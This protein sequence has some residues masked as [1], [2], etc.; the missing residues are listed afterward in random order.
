MNPETWIAWLVL[1]LA[2]GALTFAL[3]RRLGLGPRLGLALA[4]L[5][6]SAGFAALYLYSTEAQPR[7]VDLAI[8]QPKNGARVEGNR[9]RVEGVAR[10]ASSLVTLVVRSE[11]DE[12]WWV[13]DVVRPD[14]QSGLWLIDAYLGTPTEGVRQSFTIVALASDDGVLL[15]V[16]AGRRLSRGMT[17]ATVPLWNRSSP[18]VVWRAR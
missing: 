15:N 3:A 14:P 13:Q 1:A 16:L 2:A 9:L 17:L 5:G 18:C 8:R 4:L 11:S 10:P 12:R 6:A 7:K